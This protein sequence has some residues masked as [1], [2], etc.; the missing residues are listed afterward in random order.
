MWVAAGLCSDSVP[1][2]SAAPLTTMLSRGETEAQRGEGTAQGHRA[3]GQLG[4]EMAG[5]FPDQRAPC[6][7]PR[8]FVIVVEQSGK[9]GPA[10]RERPQRKL[11]WGTAQ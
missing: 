5:S 2:P 1:R 11:K 7:S 3:Q 9:V 6:S 4:L 10:G 8:A